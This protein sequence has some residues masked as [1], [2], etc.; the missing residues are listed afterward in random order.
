MIWARALA[1]TLCL[2]GTLGPAV[3]AT[4]DATVRNP[5]GAPVEDAA[6]VLEPVVASAS[7]VR[8]TVTIEQRDREFVPYLTIVET[9]TLV[10]FPNRDPFKHHIYSFSPAKVF[11]I[12]LYAGK[13]VQPVLFDKPGEVALGCNIHDWMEAYVLVVNTPHFGKTAAD[14]HVVVRDVPPGAYRLRVWHPRQKAATPL[15]EIEVGNATLKLDLQADPT[16]RL[17][18]PKPPVDSDHY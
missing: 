16:A 8:R 3:A 2:L 7:K 13:P 17:S 15:R 4:V 10:E 5:S 11:E 14:G 18:K 1:T 12:K 6:V 9:G